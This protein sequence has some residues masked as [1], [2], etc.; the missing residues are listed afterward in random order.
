M[1]PGLSSE[2]YQDSSNLDPERSPYGYGETDADITLPYVIDSE[3]P[4]SQ[5]LDNSDDDP[6]EPRTVVWF[7]RSGREV[8]RPLHLRE[9]SLVSRSVSV[10]AESIQREVLEQ[11][12]V[13]IGPSVQVQHSLKTAAADVPQGIAVV[14]G[15]RP[16][17]GGTCKIYN[18]KVSTALKHH[19]WRVHLS[20]FWRPELACWKCEKACAGEADLEER[21]RGRCCHRQ[22][23][24]PELVEQ[25]LCAT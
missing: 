11:T 5:A 9:S 14:V 20:W 10:P 6:D 25:G 22:S 15:N 16:M 24:L 13:V 1:H 12:T 18:L 7:T 8:K 19:V 4:L 23:C 21:L 2:L 17:D 3:D